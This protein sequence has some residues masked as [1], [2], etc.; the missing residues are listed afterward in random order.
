MEFGKLLSVFEAEVE[1]SKALLYRQVTEKIKTL[2]FGTVP[3]TSTKKRAKRDDGAVQFV[4]RCI[5]SVRRSRSR[6]W[7]CSQFSYLSRSFRRM[8]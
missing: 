1:S 7:R 5:A 6:S 3:T 4:H 2:V 8:G